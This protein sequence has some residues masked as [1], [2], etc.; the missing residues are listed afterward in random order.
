MTRLVNYI[1]ELVEYGAGITFVDIDETVFRTFAKILVI[2]KNTGKIIRELDNMEFNSYMLQPNEEYD[3]AQFRDA[4]F[5]RKTSIPIDKTIKRIKKMMAS[6]K[7]KG[8]GSRIIFLTARSDFDDKF[9]VL[10]TFKDHGISMDPSIFHIERAGNDTSGTIPEIKQKI[11]MKYLK[12]G[13]YRRVRLIDDHKPNVNALLDIEK[14]FGN[15]L[16]NYIRKHYNIP[17]TEKSPLI[18]Y[19][20]LW[21]TPSGSLQQIK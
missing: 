1:N 10:N 11:M 17:D 3:F 8:L 15:E 21:V 13:K 16:D 2:D 18:K 5:F 12:T 19:F 20:G 7:E 6:I 9:E 4:A 14:K